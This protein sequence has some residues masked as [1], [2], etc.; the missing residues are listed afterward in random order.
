MNTYN[1]KKLKLLPLLNV[2]PAMLLLVDSVVI[3]QHHTRTNVDDLSLY[4]L[5]S[6]VY[7]RGLHARFS[8]F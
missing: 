5:Y 2:D 4:L 8:G 6:F 1:K 7:T 3:Y